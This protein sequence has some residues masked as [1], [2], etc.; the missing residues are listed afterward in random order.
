MSRVLFA[1]SY[2]YRLDSKQWRF[3]QPY[4]PLG[5]I[6][7]A[8]V[9]REAGFSVSLFDANLSDNPYEISILLHQE[10]PAYLVIYDDGFN[11]LTKM[12]LSVMRDAAFVMAMEG[13]K[14]GCTVIISSSDSTDQVENY[15][16][17]QVDYV[18]RGEGEETLKELLLKL[19]KKLP[20]DELNGIVYREQNQSI[21]TSLR[22]VLRH[23]D[24][25]P[26]PAWDLVTIDSYR[27]LWHS[28]H[29]YFSLNIATT[30]GCPYKCNWCAKPIYGNRY[31]SRSPQHVINEIEFLLTHFQ[32]DHFWMCDDIFGLKP[33]WVAEF[34]RLVTERKLKFKYKIQSR[35]DLLQDELI[36]KALAASGAETVWIGAESGSQKILDAMDKGITVN[37]IRTATQLLKQYNIK[38][39]FFLQFGYLGETHEDIGSTIQLVLELMPG[40]IGISV[41]YPLPGTKFYDTVKSMLKE[42][43]NWTDSDDLSMM[44]KNTYPAPYYKILHRYVHNRYRIQRGINQLKQSLSFTKDYFKNIASMLYNIPL[45]WLHAYQLKKI[46]RIG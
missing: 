6:Q 21:S 10:K 5:T 19:D 20:V 16:D 37:Q 1:N 12:C 29:G 7:A 32:P 44:F 23:L 9:I 26:M 36:I 4:P 38:P 24:E 43:K 8:A 28:H 22:A 39:A 41:S 34:S 46:T 27:N 11:Y 31:N 35:A 42:K 14:A 3:K 15:L 40:E 45:S 30:R 33:G 18:I 2:F 17:H 25:L 13:K